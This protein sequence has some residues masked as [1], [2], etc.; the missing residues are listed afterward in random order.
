MA[1]VA[2]AD[3]ALADIERLISDG[4]REDKS[5]EYKRDIPRDRAELLKDVSAFANASGGDL[6][7]GIAE[8]KGLPT[9]IVGLSLPDPDAEVLR[10]LQIIQTGLQPP[11]VLSSL[12]CKVLPP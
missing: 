6:V 9:Q 4:V 12:D 11:L 8:E 3:L 5:I 2:L 7:F 10:L 1:R